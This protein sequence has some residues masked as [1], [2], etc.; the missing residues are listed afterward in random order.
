[1]PPDDRSAEGREGLN[2]PAGMRPE[3]RD[4]FLGFLAL[5]DRLKHTLRAAHTGERR[6]NSAEHAWHVALIAVTLA[7]EVSPPPDLA[8]VLAMIAVH[9]VVEI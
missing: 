6:E 9:D 5:A 3:R 4:A 2:Q 8:A 1:M 7:E